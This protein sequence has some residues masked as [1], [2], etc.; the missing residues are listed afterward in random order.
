VGDWAREVLA[1]VD[2]QEEVT[3]EEIF[4]R[5]GEPPPL[6]PPPLR[7]N[8]PSLAESIQI[9]GPR[10]TLSI[11]ASQYT[12]AEGRQEAWDSAVHVLQ[13]NGQWLGNQIVGALPLGGSPLAAAGGGGF[14]PLP[15][16]GGG[17]FGPPPLFGQVA[18]GFGI[19]HIGGNLSFS[20]NVN[21][22]PVLDTGIFLFEILD[23][24]FEDTPLGE[25]IHP[26]HQVL[27]TDAAQ[28]VVEHANFHVEGGIQYVYFFQTEQGSGFVYGGGGPGLSSSTSNSVTI[29]AGGLVGWGAP[30]GVQDYQGSSTSGHVNVNNILSNPY[31]PGG[32][33]VYGGYY[34]SNSS[35]AQ[36][37]QLG[38]N[39]T[40]SSG[41]P[42]PSVG[43]DAQVSFYIPFK[44]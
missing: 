43:G 36:G 24:V 12:T 32:F 23:D 30:N 33:G 42:T 18:D 41:P 22:R 28:W 1:W 44:R 31:G 13:S 26:V 35:S 11:M 15:A 19:D 3:W 25:V 10:E 8:R 14:G 5:F 2:T 17:G 6:P 37:V 27:H 39:Y 38:F 21:V 9:L 4:E 40:Y 7:D 29:N 20:I 34:H 16:A